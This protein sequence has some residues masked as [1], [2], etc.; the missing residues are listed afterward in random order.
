VYKLALSSGILFAV[1]MAGYAQGELP[2]V[3]QIID[4]YVTA[5]GGKAAIEKHRTRVSKGSVEVVTFGATGTIELFAKAPNKQFSRS[6][7]DGYGQVLQGFDGKVAWSKTPDTGLRELGGEELERA[8]ASADFYVASHL[9][10]RYTKMSVAGQGKAGY[11]AA[12][13]IAAESGSGTEK[14]Y[15]DTETGLLVRIESRSSQGPVTISFADYKEAD[16]VKL[17]QTI[18]Q[19]TEQLTVVIKLAQVQHDVA[20]DD[21]MFAKPAN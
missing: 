20:V 21:A 18:R 16:G 6:E 12:Y 13:I 4:K 14:L 15:F 2:G 17:P 10:D 7:F 19:E 1:A 5:S 9:K 8:K 11:R 3:D